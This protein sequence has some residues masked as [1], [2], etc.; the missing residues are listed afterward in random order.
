VPDGTNLVS[1]ASTFAVV[2]PGSST[3][4]V[5][6][7]DKTRIEV[8]NTAASI[9]AYRGR[10]VDVNEDG[11][12]D[13]AALFEATEK[14]FAPADD[15][16]TTVVSEDGAIDSQFI[17]DGPIGLHFTTNKGENYLVSNI[18][19]LGAPV[20]LPDTDAGKDGRKP[21]VLT[22]PAEP[23]VRKTA[24]T[25]VS[26]NPFNP[27]TTVHFTLAS[28]ARVQIAIYDVTGSL[29]RRLVDES[30]PA[31][32]HQARWD[33][34]NDAG[35]GATTGVYFVRMVAGSHSEVRKIVMLK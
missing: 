25:S 8:G 32:E 30:M 28:A 3:F 16:L 35:H 33:G 27:Q 26:P 14:I 13:L 20:V 17:S 31:G 1:N 4:D 12:L 22:T 29:V 10:T 15:D 23:A 34:F 6:T 11:F 2:I 5:N 18:Y 9:R 19:A 24:L 7:I 21:D